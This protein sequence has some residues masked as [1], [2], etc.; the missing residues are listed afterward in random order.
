MWRLVFSK[1]KLNAQKRKRKKITN[2]P[3]RLYLHLWHTVAELELGEEYQ[4]VEI[5][6]YACG[7]II[8]KLYYS[9][10]LELIMCIL[11]GFTTIH[12]G[13]ILPPM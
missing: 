11:W 9:A 4:N 2:N 8:E 10:E 6:D 5:R 13:R 1:Y 3:R 7:D 12:A